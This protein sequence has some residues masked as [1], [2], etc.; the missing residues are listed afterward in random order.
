MWYFKDVTLV[1][2]EHPS[3]FNRGSDFKHRWKAFYTDIISLGAE[4]CDIRKNTYDIIDQ[5]D[6]VASIGG[7]VV[8]EALMRNKAAIYFG[9]GPM[10]PISGEAIH[11]YSNHKSLKKFIDHIDHLTETHFANA[12][13]EYKKFLIDIVCR[14]KYQPMQIL[15][16]S[17]RCHI[18][19]SI[20][21]CIHKIFRKSNG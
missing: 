6:L 21:E 18:E 11:K 7:T 20:V 3:T 16:T 15:T 4:L 17:R 13:N 12:R 10:Y 9:L 19:F 14:Q 1:V 5:A 8:G 2:K